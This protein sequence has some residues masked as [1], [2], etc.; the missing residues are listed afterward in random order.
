MQSGK[1]VCGLGKD[2]GEWAEPDREEI[3]L[4]LFLEVST[5]FMEKF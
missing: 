5:F 4:Q 2:E 1:A 3:L